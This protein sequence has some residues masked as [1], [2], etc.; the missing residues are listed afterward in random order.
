MPIEI[1]VLGA[2]CAKCKATLALIEQV[3][4]AEG[5][6]AEL[7]KVEDMQEIMSHGIMSTP[8]I[9]VNGKMKMVGRVPGREQ[10]RE[11]LRDAEQPLAKD[12]R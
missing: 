10:V 12:T 2:G 6:D 11:W 3:I 4:E 7:T 8:G 1:K 5:A 9:M